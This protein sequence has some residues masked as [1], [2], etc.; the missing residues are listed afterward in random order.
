MALSNWKDEHEELHF[1]ELMK[2]KKGYFLY[3]YIYFVDFAHFEDVVKKQ[4][5]TIEIIH[6]SMHL[7][8]SDATSQARGLA[9]LLLNSGRKKDVSQRENQN[10]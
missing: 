2:E 5:I 7:C 4:F 8:K 3:S 6:S 1:I 9:T 10:H